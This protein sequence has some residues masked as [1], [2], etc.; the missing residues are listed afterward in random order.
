MLFV[1]AAVLATALVAGLY[2][3]SF[4]HGSRFELSNANLDWGLFGDYVGGTLG[5]VFSLLAFF[6]VL[7]TVWLQASQ[8]DLADK[9]AQLDEIQRVLATVSTRLDQLLS[10][11]VNHQ[12]KS[13]KLRSE[14]ANFFRVLSAGG[15]AKLSPTP[16]D[17]MVEAQLNEIIAECKS[18]LGPQAPVVGI[19]LDQLAWLLDRYQE[20]GGAAAVVDFYRRRYSA[21]ACWLDALGFVGGHPYTQKIFMPQS[22]REVLTPQPG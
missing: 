3:I 11:Q 14:P 2:F 12:F 21:V 4:S 1:A 6:G 13:Y 15:T 8:L 19:E 7:C 16:S 9:Q 17:W 18:A 22:L 10:D 20:Q 5:T